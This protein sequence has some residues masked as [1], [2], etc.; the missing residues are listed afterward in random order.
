MKN[1]KKHLNID[2]EFLDKNEK[3]KSNLSKDGTGPNS[4]DDKSPSVVKTT[5]GDDEYNWKHSLVIIGIIL[6]FGWAIF[7]G[8]NSNTYT[9]SNDWVPVETNNSVVDTNGLTTDTDIPVV[10]T[11]TPVITKTKTDDE[12]CKDSY[13]LNS[14]YTGTKNTDGNIICDCKTGYSWNSSQTACVIAKTNDQFCIESSGPHTVYNSSNNSCEC[15]SG[16]YYGAI[17]KQC[18]NLIE[19]RDQSC[20]SSYPGTSFLKYDTNGTTNICDC[21]IGYYWNNDKTAC[22]SLSAFNQSCVSSF[23]QGSYSTT[24][25]GKRVCDC[26]YG[27]SFNAQRDMCVTTASIDALCERD[28]GRNSTYKGTVTNGKYNCTEPY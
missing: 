1:E 23:G 25:N 26:T 15:A 14:Y 4:S 8:N 2:L 13:G 12:N 28:I 5:S 6:F 27:Y 7:S 21:K 22:Y 16:Y 3:S 20:A 9:N 10:D 11:Y 24:E 18:V 19:S 17:S